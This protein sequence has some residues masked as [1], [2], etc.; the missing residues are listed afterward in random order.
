MGQH[1]LMQAGKERNSVD[2]LSVWLCSRSA[3]LSVLTLV[4]FIHA[5]SMSLETWGIH[6]SK[7]CVWGGGGGGLNISVHLLAARG[8]A[9]YSSSSEQQRSSATG[10]SLQRCVSAIHLHGQPK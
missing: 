6:M 9:Q 10:N 7:V 3:V 4:A 2:K 5:C 8:T 1:K